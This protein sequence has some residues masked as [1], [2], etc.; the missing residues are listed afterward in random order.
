MYARRR[1]LSP[2]KGFILKLIIL[3]YAGNS[4]DGNSHC[5]NQE[6]FLVCQRA[7]TGCY[8]TVTE[9]WIQASIK[10]WTV[11]KGCGKCPFQG[12]RQVYIF[13]ARPVV[14]LCGEVVDVL[15]NIVT[16]GIEFLF[17]GIR[18]KS[19]GNCGQMV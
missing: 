13:L 1:R 19:P 5:R 3:I 12:Q 18:K 9:V 10:Y 15:I 11:V 16:D 7:Y 4:L 2:K 8:K 17:H 14:I 6:D